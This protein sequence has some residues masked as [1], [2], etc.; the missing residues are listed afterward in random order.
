MYKRPKGRK[1]QSEKGLKIRKSSEGLYLMDVSS[2]RE[3]ETKDPV[4][5]EYVR[6]LVSSAPIGNFQFWLYG[7]CGRNVSYDQ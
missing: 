7:R 6:S 1:V 4:G 3:S 2:E 5:Y